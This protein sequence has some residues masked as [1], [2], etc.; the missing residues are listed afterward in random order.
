MML[1]KCFEM[2]LFGLK[3]VISNLGIGCVELREYKV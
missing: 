1:I 3:I 2:M